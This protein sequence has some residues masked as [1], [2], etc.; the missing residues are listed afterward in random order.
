MI[1]IIPLH[2]IVYKYWTSHLYHYVEKVNKNSLEVPDPSKISV[3]F[4]CCVILSSVLL[5][6]ASEQ[7]PI[8][9]KK[10]KFLLKDGR[11]WFKDLEKMVLG[12]KQHQDL[13]EK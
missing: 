10:K 12:L 3:H 11:T 5:Q 1:T 13:Q 9:G 7:F 2:V 8:L 4:H 6:L